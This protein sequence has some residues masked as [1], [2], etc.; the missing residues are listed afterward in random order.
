MF[1]EGMASGSQEGA[2]SE[3][4]RGYLR[5]LPTLLLPAACRRWGREPFRFP[6]FKEL[7]LFYSL[8]LLLLLLLLN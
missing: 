2:V 3:S 7:L 4:I 8:L 5:S 1:R 6:A